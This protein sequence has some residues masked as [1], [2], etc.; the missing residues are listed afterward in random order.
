[1]DKLLCLLW[2]GVFIDLS[3]R[4]NRGDRTVNF[5]PETLLEV[6][7]RLNSIVLE[8]GFC[9]NEDVIGQLIE[10]RCHG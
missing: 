10:E 7:L 1:M 8:L 9:G 6:G 3:Q 4:L 5:L 2:R